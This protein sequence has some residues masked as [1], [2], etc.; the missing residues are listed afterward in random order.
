MMREGE[1]VNGGCGHNILEYED[2]YCTCHAIQMNDI[3]LYGIII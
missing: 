1:R 3:D 2:S